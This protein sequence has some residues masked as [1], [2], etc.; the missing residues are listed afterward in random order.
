MWE[1]QAMTITRNTM[2]ETEVD[3]AVQP[4]A[5]LRFVS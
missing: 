4:F 3:L 1:M 2:E 5:N